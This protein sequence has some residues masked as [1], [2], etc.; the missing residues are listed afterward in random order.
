MLWTIF[1]ALMMMWLLALLSNY[2]MGGFIHLLLA[3]AIVVAIVRVIRGD[4]PIA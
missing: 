2:T 4:K 1:V 3:L